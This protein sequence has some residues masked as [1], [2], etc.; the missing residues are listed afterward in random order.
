MCTVLCFGPSSASPGPSGP[1][2]PCMS[3]PHETRAYGAVTPGL[4][5]EA[6]EGRLPDF[7]IVGHPKCGTTAICEG[8]KN[9]SQVFMPAI[10]EP[11]FFALD[12]KK[13]P[14]AQTDE[15][16]PSHANRLDKYLDLFA[17][18]GDDQLAGESSVFYLWSP[19][20][21]R[22]I[23]E[24]QSAAKIIAILR[25]P[26]SL[27]NS[28]YLQFS[29]SGVETAK[30]FREAIELE[31]SRRSTD[32]FPSL[33]YADY[34]KYVEQIERY[35][36]EFPA[37]QILILLLDDLR[38]ENQAVMGQIARFLEIDETDSL[39][40]PKV[41]PTVRVRSTRLNRVTHY[42]RRRQNPVITG[43]KASA[44]AAF[45]RGTRRRAAISTGLNGLLYG[46]PRKADDQLMS[47][48]RERF[49][50]E[51]DSLS[52]YLD[53]DLV[54]EWSYDDPSR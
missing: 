33:L 19:V 50:P 28:L 31:E 29:Q 46:E 4:R 12:R 32:R 17:D 45:P 40:A 54:S 2:V 47:S 49:R 26:A 37:D 15:A 41:N 16:P 18:A 1:L 11:N 52:E 42:L 43:V 14:G 38:R 9:H 27:L 36:A 7:F 53:R 21:A 8:L 6:E 25:E 48:L 13:R 51:V 3:D 30:S 44:G 24:L 22:S 39:V 23:A 10:K 35:R 34:V 5:P 20:A